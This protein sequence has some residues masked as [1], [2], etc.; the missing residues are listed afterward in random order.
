[1]NISVVGTGYV[2]LVTGVGLSNSGNDVL[3][4]DVDE[5]KVEMLRR[6][7]S[8]IYEPGLESLM[9]RNTEE[10]RLSFTTSMQEAVS[11]AKV[12]FIAVGTPPQEDGSA[13][14]TYVKEVASSI[15]KYMQDYK[16]VVN[17]ST[18]PVGTACVVKEII[19]NELDKR[20]L[21]VDFDIVSNPEFLRE[22]AAVNDFLQPDRIVIGSNSQKATE[23]MENVYKPFVESSGEILIM[24]P[25]SSEMTK[26]TA[27]AMLAT[28]ISFMNEIAN[29]C[30]K[31]GAD[32]TK[33]KEGIGLD[34]RIGRYFINAGIGYG[35]SCF[36]KDV[37]ALEYI[38]KQNNYASNILQAVDKVNQEQ[39]EIFANKILSYFNNDLKNKK[40]AVWGLAFKPETDDMREA[41][42]IYVIEKLAE[43]GADIMAFDPKAVGEAKK[44]INANINYE[45]KNMYKVLENAD[46]LVIH[47]EWKE[48][49]TPN[50]KKMKE[51]MKNA[52]IFDGRNIYDPNNMKNEGFEYFSVGR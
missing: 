32:I 14:L 52:V 4:M 39:R 33:V 17:K 16:V 38:A 27:N 46:V 1:M 31:T 36:P 20:S 21:K 43:K 48:F 50:F 25:L 37:K 26:Y 35:G 28:K 5:N 19:Q 8:P 6:S 22:G 7:E 3:C 18:V 10:G 15:G 44:E 49:S 12:I 40:V 34:P 29:I 42:S 11:F 23:I 24:D 51:L 30:E 13:D 47:T 2:G 9:K 45:D 41:P